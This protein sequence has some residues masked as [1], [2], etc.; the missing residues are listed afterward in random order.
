MS[1]GQRRLVLDV[2]SGVVVGCVSSSIYFDRMTN[3]G[4]AIVLMWTCSRWDR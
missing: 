4:P 1:L 2:W 3:S